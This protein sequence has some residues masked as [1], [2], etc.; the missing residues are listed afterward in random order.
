[1]TVDNQL[2]FLLTHSC[3]SC[4]CSIVTVL[5]LQPGGSTSSVPS[6]SQKL[7]LSMPSTGSQWMSALFPTRARTW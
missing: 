3:P 5:S 1:M 2:V 4:V 6:L 7:A